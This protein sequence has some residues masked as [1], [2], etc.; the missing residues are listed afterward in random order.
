MA[1]RMFQVERVEWLD[2]SQ[3]YRLMQALIIDRS[4]HGQV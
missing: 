4:R 1:R 2:D 3:L